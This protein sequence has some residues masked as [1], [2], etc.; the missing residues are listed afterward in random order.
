MLLNIVFES[1]SVAAFYPFSINLLGD[2]TTF[3]D[4][5][6]EASNIINFVSGI[7]FLI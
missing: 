3:A 5:F 2:Y 1:L 6:P 4:K 7:F